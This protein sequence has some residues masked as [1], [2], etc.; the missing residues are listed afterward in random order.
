MLAEPT[1]VIVSQYTIMLYALNYTVMY[2]SFI[3]IK[4]EKEIYFDL[5]FVIIPQCKFFS[6]GNTKMLWVKS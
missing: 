6:R 4:L 3:S 2:I 1:E 5:L